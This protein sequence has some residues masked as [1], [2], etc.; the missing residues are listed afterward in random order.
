MERLKKPKPHPKHGATKA[1]AKRYQA[2]RDLKN[3]IFQLENANKALT[4]QTVALNDE[5]R[6]L[7]TR[8]PIAEMRHIL[9][10]PYE[11]ALRL[12]LVAPMYALHSYVRDVEAL[13]SGKNEWTANG[14]S[15]AIQAYV[16]SRQEVPR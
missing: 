16:A 2:E 13:A 1:Q 3:Q 14:S 4:H 11:E 6:R 9:R 12:G 5:I 7:K 10:M 15:A 8:P